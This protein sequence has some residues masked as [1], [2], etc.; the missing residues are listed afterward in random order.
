MNL[1]SLL[2]CADEKIVRVL[3]RTLDELEIA[4]ELF[5]SAED[6]VSKLGRERFEAIIVD[7]AGPGAVEVLRSSRS[8]PLNRRAVAVAILDPNSGL[9]SAFELGANFVL[10]K[11]VTVERAKS[12]FR[13][14]RALMKKERRHNARVSVQVSVEMSS[15][16]SGSHLTVSTRDVSEGGLAILLPRRCDLG[17]RW[18]LSFRLP[19]SDAVLEVAA[20]LAWEGTETQVGLHF[21]DPSAEVVSALRE[22]IR[23][24]SPESWEFDPGIACQLT[25]LSLGA[26]YLMM[27]SP[28]PVSTRVTLSMRV[29]GNVLRAEG[30]VRVA[31]PERGMGVQFTETTPEHRQLLEKFMGPLTANHD[32]PP[33]FTVEPEGFEVEHP[34]SSIASAER[35]GETD[36]PLLRLF[37]E[38]AAL[39]ADLFMDALRDQR[40]VGTEAAGASA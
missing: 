10:Y 35:A 21:E 30:V 17:G 20:E 23:H 9:R 8:A 7:C 14:A 25:N 27:D 37:R 39:P 12:S 36:D 24:N 26:C 40:G 19:G 29:A 16:E 13:A 6:V 38:Q 15:A 22:W 3:R 31:H 33:E 5:T 34:L 2:L 4:V 28:F 32:V 18:Q 1:R 11:P